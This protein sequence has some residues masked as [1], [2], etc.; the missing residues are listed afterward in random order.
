M[1]GTAGSFP[2][3]TE[4]NSWAQHSL[5]SVDGHT[6]NL[7]RQVINILEHHTAVFMAEILFIKVCWVLVQKSR[8]SEGFIA[9]TALKRR[10]GEVG[11]EELR[12]HNGVRSSDGKVNVLQ[13][14]SYSLLFQPGTVVPHYLVYVCL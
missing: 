1:T 9:D 13:H 11:V 10:E 8:N 12:N 14:S 7:F 2:S 5:L 4:R 6:S 3:Y